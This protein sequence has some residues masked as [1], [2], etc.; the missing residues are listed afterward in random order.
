[1]RYIFDKVFFQPKIV[2]DVCMHSDDFE[3]ILSIHLVINE[4]DVCEINT[5]YEDAL[6]MASMSS[7]S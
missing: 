4:R 7:T 5:R 2:L 3:T 6:E 1:M